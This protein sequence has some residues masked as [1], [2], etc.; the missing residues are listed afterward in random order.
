[1]VR[2]KREGDWVPI[3]ARLDPDASRRLRVAAARRGTTQG[4][5][6]DELILAY[7]PAADP[8]PEPT[9]MVRKR[10]DSVPITVQALKREMASLGISQTALADSLGLNQKSV[11]EWF[12]R[13]RVPQQ[14]V[15]AIRRALEELRKAGATRKK[16]TP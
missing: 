8:L 14:R 16:R 15:P 9:R 3:T 12:L 11:N 2:P 6:L 7:L 1:M 4:R 13:D 10:D 5:I